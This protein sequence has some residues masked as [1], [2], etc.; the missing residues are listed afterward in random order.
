MTGI[1]RTAVI[2][3]A[4]GVAFTIGASCWIWGAALHVRDRV[5][6]ALT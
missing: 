3:A 6:E 4:Y 5:A 1:A 2:A